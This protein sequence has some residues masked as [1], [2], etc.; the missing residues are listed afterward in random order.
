LKN[1][2]TVSNR[3]QFARKTGEKRTKNGRKTGKNGRKTDEIRA[4]K[5]TK[6]G[7]NTGEKTDENGRKTGSRERAFALFLAAQTCGA[8]F[9]NI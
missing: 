9:R 4:K 3:P 7:Q 8:K 5:R 2:N 1:R 6:N